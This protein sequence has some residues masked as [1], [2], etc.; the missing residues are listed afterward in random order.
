MSFDLISASTA[1]TA[2]CPISASRRVV[3]SSDIISSKAGVADILLREGWFTILSRSIDKP[4]DGFGTNLEGLVSGE[5]FTGTLIGFEFRSLR[6]LARLL[7]G[8]SIA[9]RD[10][11]VSHSLSP[12]RSAW[13]CGWGNSCISSI[14]WGSCFSCSSPARASVS[15]ILLA[16]RLNRLR[17]P[18][19]SPQSSGVSSVPL[20]RLRLRF[21]GFLFG[22]S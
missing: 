13:F 18:R 16:F 11:S 21:F 5:G 2:I 12:P 22:G 3:S 17:K 9:S 4:C 14:T 1:S 15:S 20:L 10:S 19:C 6:R 8:V 7:E